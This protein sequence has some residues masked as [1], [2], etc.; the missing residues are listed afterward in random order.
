MRTSSTYKILFLLNLLSKKDY[1]KIEIQKEFE[2]NG[3]IV[4]KAS[5][6]GYFKKLSAQGIEISVSKDKKENVYHFEKYHRPLDLSEDDLRILRDIKKLL[7]AQKNYNR[8][9]KTHRLFYKLALIAKS[10]DM[11]R[12]LLDFGYYSTLNWRLV[13]ELEEHC[14]NKDIVQIDYILP[15]GGNKKII[16]HTDDLKIGEW[17]NR[18]YLWGALHDAPQLSYLPVDRIYMVEKVIKKN[19]PFHIPINIVTYKISRNL[20]DEIE[21]EEKETLFEL[22]EKFATIKRPISDDFFLVQRLMSFCPDL[23]YISDERIRKMVKEKLEILKSA[24]EKEFD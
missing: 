10:D 18:L 3:L 20:F 15:A 17:S 23:Y 5:L 6:A 19:A 21:L 9:R 13:R 1:T 16:I 11:K 4:S 8:I 14:K 2:K 22:N 24:Y 7:F 12:E